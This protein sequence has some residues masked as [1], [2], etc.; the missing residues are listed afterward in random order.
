MEKIL[1]IGN[2]GYYSDNLN[3]QT[4]K[5]RT[6]YEGLLKYTSNKEINYFDTS[7]EGKIISKMIHIW[8]LIFLTFK[9]NTIILMPAQKAIKFLTPLYFLICK[10]TNKKVKMVAI[11]GWLA[12]FLT[13]NEMYIK[14]LDQFDEIYVELSS[15]KQKLEKFGLNNVVHF[16]N[17]RI[18]EENKICINKTNE[19][20]E[21]VFFSRVTKEKGI[22]LAVSAINNINRKYDKNIKLHVYGP[23]S[24]EYKNQFVKLAE[25]NK[26]I[27]YKG[28]ISPNEILSVLSQYDLMIFPTYYPGEGFPGAI[29]DALT[30]GVPIVASDWKYNSEILVDGYTGLLVTA[31]DQKD[32]TNALENL[33][34]NTSLIN[35]MKKNCIAESKKYHASEIMPILIE[36]I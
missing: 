13:N 35:K 14:F 10:L 18:Y 2:F 25:E 15:L 29:L 28:I 1:V 36:N 9:S 27:L 7:E 5:T 12:D 4:M 22:E 23:V 26:N 33:I 17:F 31:K 34:P 11:G 20:Q 6:I 3:G 21:V 8:R 19:V 30:A 32:L 16:P 24:E